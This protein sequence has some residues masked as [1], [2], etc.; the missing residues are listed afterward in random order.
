MIVHDDFDYRRITS[1]LH[2]SYDNGEYFFSLINLLELC[3][4]AGEKPELEAVET[5]FA[6]LEKEY[7]LVRKIYESERDKSQIYMNTCNNVIVVKIYQTM[8]GLEGDNYKSDILIDPEFETLH[9]D[10]EIYKHIIEN[11]ATSSEWD[12]EKWR[13]VLTERLRDYYIFSNIK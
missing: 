2:N 1:L 11:D 3:N 7:N 12:D 5:D 10:M 8:E 13:K 9:A 6:K 4:V